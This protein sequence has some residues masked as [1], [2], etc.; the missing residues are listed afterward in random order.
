VHAAHGV[1]GRQKKSSI[2][3]QVK[4]LQPVAHRSKCQWG[5]WALNTIRY[6]SQKWRQ[7]LG[8]LIEGC[9]H[10]P[11]VMLYLLF[12]GKLLQI[13]AACGTRDELK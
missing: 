4:V 2:L 8:G 1:T 11:P 9:N 12:D 5:R 7:F 13:V 3:L 10:A 6:I